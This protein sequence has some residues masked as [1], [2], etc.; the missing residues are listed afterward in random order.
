MVHIDKVYQEFSFSSIEQIT[1]A[2]TD[3][4]L[5]KY[6][7]IAG[8]FMIHNE[9]PTRWDSLKKVLKKAGKWALTKSVPVAIGIA[10]GSLMAF[11]VPP[12]LTNFTIYK[13]ISLKETWFV[14]ATLSILPQEISQ[15]GVLDE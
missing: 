2:L 4:N 7:D 13:R 5:D 15:K 10:M 3:W 14:F 11:A 6:Y 8:T 12:S 9:K 1:D